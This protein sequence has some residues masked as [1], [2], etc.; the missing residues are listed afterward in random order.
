MK[1]T[2]VSGNLVTFDDGSL[3]MIEIIDARSCEEPDKY[4]FNWIEVEPPKR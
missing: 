2:S 3:W 4:I 1:A